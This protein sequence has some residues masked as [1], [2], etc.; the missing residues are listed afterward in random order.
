M[1]HAPAHQ[2]TLLQRS[3]R[4]RLDVCHACPAM[5]Y[6]L[7]TREGSDGDFWIKRFYADRDAA[8]AAYQQERT[9]AA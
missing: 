6:I 5:P 9:K 4:A 7:R 1:T 3:D 8:M 2:H